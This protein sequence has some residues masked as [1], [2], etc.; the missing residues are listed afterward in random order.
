M[1][2][3]IQGG[4]SSSRQALLEAESTSP[5][6]LH[7]PCGKTRTTSSSQKVPFCPRS[8]ASRFDLRK[9]R[10]RIAYN[11]LLAGTPQDVAT[12]SR[13]AIRR[14]IPHANGR[15]SWRPDVAPLSDF[16]TNMECRIVLLVLENLSDHRRG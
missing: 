3:A 9:C 2:H 13:L 16:L 10:V 1:L 14:S 7:G 12:Q 11:Q 15:S 6:R 8:E 5:V 4:T